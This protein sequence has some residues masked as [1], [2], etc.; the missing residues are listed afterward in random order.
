MRIEKVI[1]ERNTAVKIYNRHRVTTK[2]IKLVLKENKPIFKKVGG[3]QYMAIGLFH[4]HV[5]IFFIYD[6]QSKIA[7]IKT[8]YPSSKWQINLYKRKK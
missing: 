3:G 6:K 4:R 8:A 5:T 2:E 1:V 7:D